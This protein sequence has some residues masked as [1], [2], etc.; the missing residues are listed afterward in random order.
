MI[1]IVRETK[2]LSIKMS[3]LSARSF[4]NHSAF[5]IA[6]YS[7]AFRILPCRFQYHPPCRL[8]NANLWGGQFPIFNIVFIDTF[9]CSFDN[10]SI[11]LLLQNNDERSTS[12][13]VC[14]QLWQLVDQ[15]MCDA[16]ISMNAGTSCCT[17]RNLVETTER[18]C[19]LAFFPAEVCSAHQRG[20]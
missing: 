16:W 13:L 3:I 20:E 5:A 15:P 8:P 9:S 7:S 12:T 19:R 1:I 17:K 10:K 14:N 11:F 4:R 6:L 2:I 18:W